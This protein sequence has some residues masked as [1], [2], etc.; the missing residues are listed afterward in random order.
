MDSKFVA[1]GDLVTS[2]DFRRK[3]IRSD[4][5]EP[6]PYPYWGASGI[7]DYVNEYLF[8]EP[9][10][11]ISE[12]GENLKTRKT[13]ISFF[14]N[15][16]IWVN[17][18][19]HVFTSKT[20]DLRFLAQQFESLDIS[21]YISGST[22]PKLTAKNLASLKIWCPPLSEQRRIAGVLGALDDLIE[23]NISIAE[24]LEDL[25]R[26]Y[27]EQVAVT[28]KLADIAVNNRP[29]PLKPAGTVEYYSLPAFDSERQ[30]EFI[31]GSEIRSNKLPIFDP[32]VLISRLNPHIPRV[33]MVYPKVGSS[34]LASTEFVPLVGNEQ[35]SVELIYAVTSSSTFIAQ[36]QS[37]VTGTTG[38]HQRVDKAILERLNVPDVRLLNFGH[39]DF[40]ENAI[41]EASASRKM[42]TSLRHIRDELL[43]LLMSGK[44]RVREAET[45]VTALAKDSA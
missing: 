24:A 8:D 44:I 30:P 43:P 45:T 20:A 12:D 29:K 15:G 22:Q 21:G 23:S 1:F 31:D 36:M 2:L 5:R 17:N 11:L 7:V 27:V 9:V 41:K 4:E 28:V 40:I 37:L 10:L 6:G 13:P 32:V 19:A 25:S 26:T 33:W 35:V 39:R 42:A 14:V 38:S 3:P 34:A 18:H 16:K